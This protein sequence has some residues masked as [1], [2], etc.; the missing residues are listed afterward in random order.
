M[1]NG[2]MI[3]RKNTEIVHVIDTYIPG[4]SSV[5]LYYLDLLIS[6]QLYRDIFCTQ[7]LNQSPYL[8]VLTFPHLLTKAHSFLSFVEHG[9]HDAKTS[10]SQNNEERLFIKL[11]MHLGAAVQDH[12]SSRNLFC[13]AH[14]W[15]KHI[16][17]NILNKNK[18]S[19]LA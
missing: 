13:M 17:S 18:T 2:H 6:C 19:A 5:F 1:P 3:T 10:K 15:W 4:H 11:V 16:P 8:K 7:N 9:Q 14:L 12:A